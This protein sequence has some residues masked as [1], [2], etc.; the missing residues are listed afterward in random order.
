MRGNIA[1]RHE[2]S[3]RVTERSKRAALR[4]VIAPMRENFAYLVSFV[5]TR[6]FQSLR[7]RTEQDFDD[8]RKVL[9]RREQDGFVRECH[10]DLHLG[11]L[12]RL[13]GGIVPFVSNSTTICALST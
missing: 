10:G 2:H 3:P 12:V 9:L 7:T 4:D 13:P 11:N 1:D 5:D 6:V 8:L